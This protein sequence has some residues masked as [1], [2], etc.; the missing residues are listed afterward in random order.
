MK[1]TFL[2]GLEDSPGVTYILL[3]LALTIFLADLFSRFLKRKYGIIKLKEIEKRIHSWWLIWIA[4]SIA[5]IAGKI[6]STFLFL[7][8]SALAMNEFLNVTGIKKSDPFAAKISFIPIPFQYWFVLNNNYDLFLTSIPVLTLFLFAVIFILRQDLN[9]FV[10]KLG[11]LQWGQVLCVFSLSH[12]ANLINLDDLHTVFIEPLG[13]M[14]YL[15]VLSQANDVFQFIWGKLLGRHKIL[16]LVSPNKTVEGFLGGILSTTLLAAL[17]GPI[18]TIMS[19]ELCIFSG[20]LIGLTGFLGDALMSSIKR[21]MK[22][23]DFGS[24]IPGHGGILDRV[25]SLVIAA[26]IFFHFYKFYFNG[27]Y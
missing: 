9:N 8:I 3:G 26:P 18:L 14:T 10:I 4:T 16:S 20:M 23:K 11:V 21:D 12:L 25:D 17:I 24:F 6:G 5:M 15:I 22:V 27:F 7:C 2:R 13:L 19:I 1:L